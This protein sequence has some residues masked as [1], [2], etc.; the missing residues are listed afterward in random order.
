[1]MSAHIMYRYW[2]RINSGRAVYQIQGFY[3]TKYK[4]NQWFLMTSLW[5]YKKLRTVTQ[6]ALIP[7]AQ[8]IKFK[9]FTKRITS[10]ISDFSWRHYDVITY[11]VPLLK[12]H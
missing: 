6:A 1:M 10:E 4:R 7:V 11:S 12:A 5:R 3:K 8:Y 9:V 2:S